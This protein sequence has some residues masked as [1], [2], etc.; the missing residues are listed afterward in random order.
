MDTS[1]D[2][3]EVVHRER[4]RIEVAVPS[5]DVEGVVVEDVGLIAAPDAHLHW[6]LAL[7]AVRVQHLRRMDVAVVVGSTLEHLAVLVAIAARDL[8]LPRRLDDQVALLAVWRE[9]VGRPARDDD[10][11]TFLVR[12]VA[13]DRLERARALVDEH[14]LV[15]LAVPEEVVHLL[16]RPA[17]R[18]LDVVVSHQHAPAGDLVALGVDAVGLEVPVCVRVGNPFLALDLLEVADLHHAARRLEVVEDRLHPDEALHPHHLFGE[19]GA[20]VA[21]LRM[22]LSRY[23]ANSLIERHGR[24]SSPWLEQRGGCRWRART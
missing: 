21:K 11:V 3:L 20:V 13:E 5:D 4:P 7:V 17:E 9:A 6:E 24:N 12:H 22:P 10:V 16:L 19:E 14:H 23:G 8:D 18:D 2:R 1:G 15:A